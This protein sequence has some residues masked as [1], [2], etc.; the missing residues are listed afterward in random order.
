MELIV[1]LTLFYGT[2]KSGD[3]MD[4]FTNK[5]TYKLYREVGELLHPV[6]SKKNISNYKIVFNEEMMPVRVFYPK[7]VS[8]L[9]DVII[10]VPGIA[11]ITESFQ[12]YGDIAREMA[13][14]TNKVVIALD[15]EEENLSYINLIDKIYEMIIYLYEKL[16]KEAILPKNITLLG[17]SIGA[18]IIGAINYRNY[19]DKKIPIEKNVLLYPPVSG[20]YFG[21]SQFLSITKNDKYDLLVVRNLRDFYNK[22][23]KDNLDN[24]E[25]FLLKRKDFQGFAKT[26]LI[27]GNLDPLRDEIEEFSNR[28]QQSNV[29]C[30]Y[31]NLAFENHGFLKD[32]DMEMKKELYTT[33]KD[34]LEDKNV[35]Q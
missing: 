30:D 10:Y 28:L 31:F 17:D 29:Q 6:I 8:F 34:F 21:K 3:S 4:F 11:T 27:S 23:A 1:K 24:E 13:L 35:I 32:V 14:S 12:K 15:Y 9:S 26:L 20:E 5:N 7:K 2:I 18:S 16:E 19:K 22:Y 25:V 33:I